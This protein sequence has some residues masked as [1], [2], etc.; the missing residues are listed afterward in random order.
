MAPPLLLAAGN[1]GGDRSTDF[2]AVATA[3]DA[4]ADAAARRRCR[5]HGRRRQRGWRAECSADRL[6]V[7]LQHRRHRRHQRRRPCAAERG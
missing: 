7:V 3:A 2:C 6:C 1:S 5:R 4:D